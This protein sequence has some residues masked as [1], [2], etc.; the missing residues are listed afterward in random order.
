MGKIPQATLEKVK[1]PV[2]GHNEACSQ[3][4]WGLAHCSPYNAHQNFC[5][6]PEVI[7]E[8]AYRPALM[9]TIQ[10]YFPGRSEVKNPPAYA[11]DAGDLSSIPESG[12]SLGEGNGTPLQYSC[13]GN[14]TDR[15]A[16]RATVHEVAKSGTAAA[17]AKSLQSCLALCDPIDGSPPGSP[18]PGILQGR[19]LE[20]VAISFS[21]HAEYIQIYRYFISN[22][23]ASFGILP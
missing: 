22:N 18:V 10:I 6:S 3:Q 9:E 23:I 20:W 11:E 13:Q 16:W 19:T 8:N 21:K 4:I 17:A 15:E 1:R 5:F 7:I 12:S 2:G 14:S